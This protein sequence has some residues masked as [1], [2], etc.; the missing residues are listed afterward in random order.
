MINYT[1][2]SDPLDIKRRDSLYHSFKSIGI[3]RLNFT[4]AVMATRMS[5]KEVYSHA[6]SD[7]F[8][9]KGE[10]GCVLSHK[11]VYEEFLNSQYNSIIIFEDDAVFTER[12]SVSIL[13][14]IM[15]IVDNIDS[16]VVVALQK[17]EYQ[18]KE[19][20]IITDDISMYSCHKFY[21]THGYIIN[22]AAAKNILELQ[23]PIRFEI[24]AFE[25]YYWLG[26]TELYCLNDDLVLQSQDFASVIGEERFAPGVTWKKR[27]ARREEI[28]KNV[29]ANL[30]FSEK[31]KAEI[32]H[33]K[34]VL[35]ERMQLFSGGGGNLSSK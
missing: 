9:T 26:V 32:K 6:V 30:P 35:H 15:K 24:D 5:D 20:F 16:P 21:C 1:I 34:R 33:F 4:N 3:K 29:Y 13:K 19:K 8:L 25:Y 27:M 22:R 12:C 18:N 7:T 11:K 31:L 17:S 23:T 28:Y 2:I 10:V 14:D